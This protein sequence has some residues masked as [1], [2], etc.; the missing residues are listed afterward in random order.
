[1]S[2]GFPQRLKMLMMQ[3]NIT[4]AQLARGLNVDPS[5]ISRWLKQGCG[6]RKAAEHVR[7]G[8]EALA[9]PAA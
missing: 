5:L 1:M 6:E 7:L 8:P 4:S 2:V 9:E 3:L